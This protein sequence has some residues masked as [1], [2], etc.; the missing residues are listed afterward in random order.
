MA[1]THVTATRNALA[2]A[3]ADLVDV[4]TTNPNGQ[5]VFM[6]GADVEVAT[7]EMSNPAFGE[8]SGGAITANAITADADATGGS[9]AL[10]KIVNRDGT[11]VYRGSVGTSGADINLSSLTIASGDTVSVSSVVYNASI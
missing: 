8:A 1:I 2:N 7:L 4:G 5:L 11:E 3:V 9:V 6:T 10:F